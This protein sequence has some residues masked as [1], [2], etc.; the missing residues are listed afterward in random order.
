MKAQFEKETGLWVITSG[1]L[2]GRE[3]FA[4]KTFGDAM[5]LFCRAMDARK[6]VAA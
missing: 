2:F 4:G 5:A 1:R 3:E 6:K